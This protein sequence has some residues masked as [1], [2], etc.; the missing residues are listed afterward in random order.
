MLTRFHRLPDTFDRHYLG[1]Y[2][3]DYMFGLCWKIHCLY[4]HREDFRHELA[5][6]RHGWIIDDLQRVSSNPL[7]VFSH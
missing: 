3:R 4:I 7:I 5:G 1:I 2:D 6:V